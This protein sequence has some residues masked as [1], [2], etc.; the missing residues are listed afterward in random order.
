MSSLRDPC[1]YREEAAHLRGMAARTTNR[2][3]RDSYLGLALQYERLATV[4]EKAATAVDE[5]EA[6]ELTADRST[7]A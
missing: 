5:T 6:A 2:R 3:L 1:R 7:G 4:L